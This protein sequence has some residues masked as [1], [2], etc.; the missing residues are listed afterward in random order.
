ML[1]KFA[2]TAA[3]TVAVLGVGGVSLASTAPVTHK[4]SAA[5]K[6]P[7][8]GSV[9][10]VETYPG[11]IGSGAVATVACA[12]STAASKKFVAISGGFEDDPGQNLG[13]VNPLSIA[14]SF[15]GRMNWRTNKP[16]AHRLD[17]WVVQFAA[18]DTSEANGYV[19]ALCVPRSEFGKLPVQTNAG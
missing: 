14:A 6:P 11:G 10:R 19:W 5:S 4:K 17:G 7:L 9:Y 13:T 18:T 1:K 8:A 16:Y 15:P 12:N 2:L 3:A